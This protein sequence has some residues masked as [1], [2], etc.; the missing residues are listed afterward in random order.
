MAL[1]L[2][3]FA[4]FNKQGAAEKVRLAFV[5]GG[6]TFEDVRV[7]FPDWPAMK[8][9]ALYGK[10]PLLQIGDAEPMAQGDAMLRYAGRL[11]TDKG[12]SL[13]PQC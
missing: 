3:Y 6:I 9:T 2:T 11:A 10:L 4:Y 13:Y 12:V 8:P 7:A 5:L 1:R